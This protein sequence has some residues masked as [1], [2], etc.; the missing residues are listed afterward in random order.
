MKRL[1]DIFATI[2]LVVVSFSLCASASAYSLHGL[3]YRAIGPAIAGGRTPAI[4]GSNADPRIYYAGG[5]GG[6]VFKTTDGGASWKPVFDDQPVAPIG[7]ISVAPDSADDVWV[8]TGEAN[9]RN[10]VE[11][12]DGIW[13]STDGGK[14]WKHLGLDDAGS[15]SAISIDPHDP[16]H[17]V[18]GALGQIFRDNTTRGI[19]VT[20]DGGIHWTRTLYL[21]P[22]I[23]AS[24]VERAADDPQ[25][26]YAGM[27]RIRRQPW[28]LSSGGAGGGLFQ[29]HDG[30]MSWRKLTGHGLP[31]GLTGRI[32]IAAGT[33]GRVY[34][35]IQAKAGELWRSNDG[36]LNWKLMPHSP[37]VGS[38][39]FYFS[40]IFVDPSN[41]DHVLSVG[42]SLAMSKDGGR[43]FKMAAPNAGWDYHH[44]WWSRD[45]RRIAL[46]S[47]EGVVLSADGG[48]QWWQ[49]YD[50]PFAQVYHVGYDDAAPNYHVCIGLQDDSAWCGP[51]NSDSGL[52]VLNQ[53]WIQ[54][55]T[56]DGMW[57]VY[58]P[59]DP[60]LVWSTSTNNA[61]G[62]VYLWDSRTQQALEVSPDAEKN[63]TL[64]ARNLRYRF[65]WDSPIAFTADGKALAGGNV[66]F[67]SADHG[68]HWTV[69]SPDLT[70]NE[71]A[72]QNISGGP[73][74][75]DLS[76]AETSD[77]ILDIAPSKLDAALIWVGTD[78]GLIQITRDSGASWRNVTPKEMPAW[79]RVATVEP[80]SF[81]A[82]TAF[83]AV[84]H[85]MSG[86]DRPY[87]F[88]T[89]DFGASWSSI[90]G[91]LPHDLFVRSIRQ[92][93]TNPNL[94]Y[95]GTQRGVW[96]S[97]DRGKNWQ[98]LRLNMPAS[99][100]YDIEIQPRANDLVV[101]THGR[102]VWI[103][104]DLR[105]VQELAGIAQT[106][107]HL[108][109]LRDTLRWWRWAPINWFYKN[110]LPNNIFTGTNVDYGAL[111]TYW[112]PSKTAKPPR[113]EIFDGRGR[114]VRRLTGKSAPHKAG[115]N[116]T[117]WDL[118]EDGPTK[119]FGT[120]KD[121]QGPEEG[122]DVVPGTYTVRLR[123]N[124][125]ALEQKV[126]VK[127]DPRAT[128]TPQEYQQRHDLLAGLYSELGAVDIM[129]NAID[130]RLKNRSVS[131]ARQKLMLALRERLSYDA[132]N[133]EDISR[134]TAFRERLFDLITRVSST[135]YQTPTEAQVREAARLRQMYEQLVAASK[136]LL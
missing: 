1:A 32:G 12:G 25:T 100:I 50:L 82:G 116:R 122:A 42:L 87:V 17:V 49:P 69:I 102:G 76:G 60:H 33:G 101:G 11:R 75:A 80:S 117:S 47:D 99:A 28:T 123:V 13:H 97:W 88:Q 61:T 3:E 108:F 4:A 98:P 124:G 9:P 131:V 93:P 59:L 105:A 58:D 67:Q 52:G 18:V 70:R 111:I 121:N 38:R 35:E 106:A 41:N 8:G 92:D 94:L 21:G 40:S 118:Q 113:L 14:S 39:R 130:K 20:T 110:S 63:S 120:F 23:G 16:R 74:E 62:Q 34:A 26:L 37:L 77:T 6:G 22:S 103:L 132:K 48:A 65:N 68:Q 27:Y 72:H 29:S 84:D 81:A 86:D 112:L 10:E 135:S 96:A 57:V 66:V 127:P 44:V 15:I 85:H 73:I 46:G 36:G 83:V 79:G 90:A 129:L 45:G 115:L 95:A 109:P 114:V 31:N 134:P 5:A 51:S 107:P 43:S 54:P 104:D 55:G 125:V 89:T 128:A 126:V 64:A 133:V 19:Y 78:D 91:N 7:T 136:G 71:R 119:W 2:A 53:D 56:G 30:G 24:D